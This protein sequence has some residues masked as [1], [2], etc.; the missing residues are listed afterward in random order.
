[1]RDSSSDES[2]SD[3]EEEEADGDE[4]G[5]E[6][7]EE[8]GTSKPGLSI[9]HSGSGDYL[10]AVRGTGSPSTEKRE[11]RWIRK[12]EKAASNTQSV[13]TM[14]A[15]QLLR[16]SQNLIPTIDST[17]SQPL[18]EKDNQE[19]S[20]TKENINARAAHDVSELMRLK[21]EQLEKYGAVLI[22]QSNLYLRHQMILSFL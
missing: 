7:Q 15:A 14:F 20:E 3:G 2:S 11:R 22:P 13:K 18:N 9:F 4:G 17:V 21:T 10:R 1:M 5:K 12:L 6:R 19:V 8:T 16:T